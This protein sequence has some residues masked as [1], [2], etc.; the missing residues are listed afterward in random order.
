MEP[1]ILS[2]LA[3]LIGSLVGGV[4]TLAASWLTLRGQLRAQTLVYE[5]QKRERLYA[6]FIGEAAKRFSEAWCR[7]AEGPEVIAGL[8]AHVQR[9]R[10][11]SSDAVIEAAQTAIQHVV[12]AYAAPDKDF[13]AFREIA[14][15]GDDGHALRAFSEA[16]RVELRQL[17]T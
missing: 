14:A 17:R 16:C 7:H 6:E 1:A 13:D 10:L 8:Y 12:E 9:M 15:K 5:A 11:S 4:S 2:A 3:A